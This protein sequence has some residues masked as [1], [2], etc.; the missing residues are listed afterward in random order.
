MTQN[1]KPGPSVDDTLIIRGTIIP[2]KIGLLAQSKLTFFVDNPRIYSIVRAEDNEPSQEEI[3]AALQGMEHVRILKTDIEQNG[4]L[5]D[6]IVVKDGTFEVIEGNSRLAA[7]RLLARGNAMAW[8]YI[9]CLLLP[10]TIDDSLLSTLLGQYHLKGKKEWPPYEQAGFLHRRYTKQKIE[11]KQLAEEMS[12]GRTKVKQYIDTY[13]FMIDNQDNKPSRWSYY[14]EFLK[15]RKV[16]E[17]SERFADFTPLIVDKIKSEEIDNA[18]DLRDKLPVICQAAKVLKKFV[19]GKITFEEA[20][21]EAEESGV[22]SDAYRKLNK[23]RM[24]LGSVEAQNKIINTKGP[25][26]DK[27]KYE[28]SAILSEARRVSE[29]L[30]GAK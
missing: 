21:D 28:V 3:E 20:F 27:I 19:S 8:A 18:Q 14:Y 29:K 5:I 23:F 1:A 4:G 7:Y 15:N 30:N 25:G 12:E 13:Q 9:K 24:W 2:V 16:Q 10:A 6:P 17:A 26:A 22:S 11:L